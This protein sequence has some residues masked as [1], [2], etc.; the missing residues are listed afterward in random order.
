MVR[1]ISFGS[2][3]LIY[4][5]NRLLVLVAAASIG[6]FEG[7]GSTPP[8]KSKK[9]FLLVSKLFLRQYHH[10]YRSTMKDNLS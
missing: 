6:V 9:L 8:N 4:E 1:S 5:L 10:D 7:K 3:L 2:L